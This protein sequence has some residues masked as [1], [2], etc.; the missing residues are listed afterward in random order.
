MQ[1]PIR[2][3]T[4]YVLRMLGR[5][6]RRSA[7]LLA[8]AAPA[9]VHHTTH[10]AAAA[11]AT[12]SGP[13]PRYVT[14]TPPPPAYTETPPPTPR[15]GDVWVP[16]WFKWDGRDFEWVTGRWMTPPRGTHEWVPGA[17]SERESDRQWQFVDGHWQ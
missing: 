8:L 7:A 1:S 16:G 2:P 14:K 9:C 10:T 5:L 13:P 3:V 6:I 12:D 4:V 15:P 11:T 17:W